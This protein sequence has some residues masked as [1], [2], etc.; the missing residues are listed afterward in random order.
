VAK[1]KAGSF[2][3]LRPWNG[4]HSRAFEEISFQLLKGR[5]P[6]GT[7][8]IRTGN[9]DGGVEWYVTLPDGTEHG[10]QC[11]DVQG[12][13]A[14]LTAMTD[15]VR[16]VAAE[17][18]TL[19]KLTFV[20]SWNL[21]TGKNR[22]ERK[23]QRQKYED[24][25]AVWQKEISGADKIEFGLVQESDLLDEMAKPGHWGRQWFWWDDLVLGNDWLVTRYE[26][27]WHAAS[28]KYRPDLQV[29]LPIQDD[30]LALGFDQTIVDHF[31]KLVREVIDAVADLHLR[32]DDDQSAAAL[33]EAARTA[34]EELRITAGTLAPQAG[35]AASA[36]TPLFEQAAACRKLIRE[37]HE[38]DYQRQEAWR[39]LPDD[40]PAKGSKPPEQ[41][42]PYP[43]RGLVCALDALTDWLNS[44]AGEAFRQRTYFLSGPAGSGKTHLFLDAT[45]RALDAGR[46][47]VFLAGIRL[48]EGNLWASI[49]DQLGLEPVGADV[50]LSA[51]DAV[52]EASALT[53]GRF[54]IF[55][56]ALNETVPP[57]FWST[58]LPALR[59]AVAKY[60]HV[61]LAVSCRDTYLDLVL[62]GNEGK[63]YVRQT[64]PGFA[65]REVEATQKYFAHYGLPAPKIPLLTPEF[66]LPLFLRL[67]SE[68]LSQS[69]GNPVPADGH[70]GRVIIFERYLAAKLSRI[71]RRFRPAATSGYELNYGSCRS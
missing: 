51:M 36:F 25:V 69:D 38:Y 12:I 28:E 17:R 50:L 53:G 60:P 56:D 4:E 64:H 15:S 24:K 14:L 52:G 35:D 61:S 62:E 66:T 13:D 55:I 42:N 71:A 21:A 54:V 26:E 9:P 34:A 46:P 32:K 11:K 6:V 37:T 18:S 10:W 68:S 48:G 29:D 58:H 1:L 67:Y 33:D 19:R 30:L 45:R 23:S 20:I 7:Q 43:L 22:S 65:E 57:D 3:R 27:Q 63:Q 39:Q 2:Q 49:A 40:D 31:A 47:A 8:A 5:V 41:V 70:E 16:T 59:A 44:S